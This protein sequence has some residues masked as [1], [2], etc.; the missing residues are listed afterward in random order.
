LNYSLNDNSK[1][2]TNAN[3]SIVDLNHNHNL[4]NSSN[5]ITNSNY[6]HNH[7]QIDRP[8]YIPA[9]PVNTGYAT[10]TNKVNYVNY[11]PKLYNN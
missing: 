5:L 2:Y 8:H 7:S 10:N 1:V 4:I 3:S 9:H 11:V 6:N